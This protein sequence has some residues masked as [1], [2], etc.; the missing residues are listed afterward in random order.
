M[1]D[2]VLNAFARRF[3]EINRTQGGYATE[4]T[5]YILSFSIMLLNT[6]LH[7]R[8]LPQ[9]E[10]MR[11]EDF[12]RNNRGINGGQ[13]LPRKLLTGL[14][15]S[16]KRHEMR[17]KEG[18]MW[19][20]NSL[21][22]MAPRISGWLEKKVQGQLGISRF[23]RFWFV[24]TN[25]CLFYFKGPADQDPRCIIILEAVM[26]CMGGREGGRRGREGGG[27]ERGGWMSWSSS[28]LFSERTYISSSLS[29]LGVA[30][31]LPFVITSKLIILPPFSFLPSLLCR[32]SKAPPP[33]KS[34]S[35][36]TAAGAGSSN[37]SRSPKAT[38]PP[39]KDNTPVSFFGPTLDKNAMIGSRPFKPR[40]NPFNDSIASG[41]ALHMVPPPSEV[42]LLPTRQTAAAAAVVVVVAVV[43]PLQRRVD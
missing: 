43:L 39:L 26:V 5:V 25:G 15:H 19:E 17:M 6:D 21:T 24:L 14:Y 40:L 2:R 34:S 11:L 32:Q 36:A 33:R 38:K 31:T 12:V 13:D 4:D 37:P 16:I 23:H 3:F 41:A 20:S 42:P 1:L 22:F 9:K 29:F 27:R 35:T 18:D 7:N 8:N 28:L 10:K 30:P